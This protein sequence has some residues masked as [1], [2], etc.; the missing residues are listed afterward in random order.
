MD[1]E[2]HPQPN[3]PHIRI[4]HEIH[5]EIIRR[6]FTQ[7]QHDIIN[8]ILTLSWGCGKPSAN[9]PKLNH[10]ALCGVKGNHVRKEL[11]T[12]VEHNVIIWN[13]NL[14]LFQ[15]NKHYD[16]WT[17]DVV[18][19]FDHKL[20]NDLIKLNIESSPLNIAKNIPE[21]G[22]QFPKKETENHSQN[23]DVVPESGSEHPKE[24]GPTSQNGKRKLPEKGNVISLYPNQGTA[25]E[26][27]ER[28]V[29]E[30]NNYISIIDYLNERAG[31]RYKPTTQ[32]TR[33]L[34]KARFNQGFTLDDFYTVIDNK[35]H[36]WVGT[37]MEKY[38]RPETLFGNKFEGYLNQKPLKKQKKE[39]VTAP[40]ASKQTKQ[41]QWLLERIREEEAARD[42]DGRHETVFY[43]EQRLPDFYGR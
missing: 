9:I 43:P 1:T 20:M 12:L 13:K 22:S 33:D 17:V 26:P 19:S 24:E 21:T 41:N 30:N 35:V 27:P 39:P 3:D 34:I 28:N 2:V 10:F 25:S 16:Q 38:L 37:D 6:K 29:K 7:R 31:T 40:K 32:K 36:E 42:K 5:R 14:N 23:R 4:A 15:F 18:D 8:F 11:E